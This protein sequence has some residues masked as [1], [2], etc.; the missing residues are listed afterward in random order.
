M[1]WEAIIDQMKDWVLAQGFIKLADVE[2]YL[3]GMIVA[4]SGTLGDI[5]DGWALCNGNN[6]TPDL[7]IRFIL[8][9]EPPGLFP[10]ATGGA[11]A[12]KH[13]FTT[14]GHTHGTVAHDHNFTGD[15]HFH[16][17]MP[18]KILQYGTDYRPRDASGAATGTTDP[19]APDTDQQVDTGETDAK[20]HFPPYYVLAYIM[21]L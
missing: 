21:K 1:S 10:H 17:E 12:H 7:G 3:K 8:G 2:V 6:G 18:A 5:P 13:D 19:E 9:A 20:S 11:A 15:G 14:D 16:T 4:W